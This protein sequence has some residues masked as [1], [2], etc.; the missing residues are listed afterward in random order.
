MSRLLGLKASESTEEVYLQMKE[1][2]ADSSPAA[3]DAKLRASRRSLSD[4]LA[5]LQIWYTTPS[6]CTFGTVLHVQALLFLFSW[7]RC[8]TR[9]VSSPKSYI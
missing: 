2:G 5:D 7:R 4:R 3:N 8:C 9:T 1:G 6:H